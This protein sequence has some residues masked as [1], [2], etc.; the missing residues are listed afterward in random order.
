MLPDCSKAGLLAVLDKVV[1]L[2]AWSSSIAA[3]QQT[4]VLSRGIP[5]MPSSAHSKT[6]LQQIPATSADQ[7]RG[8]AVEAHLLWPRGL[9]VQHVEGPVPAPEVDLAIALALRQQRR[10]SATGTEREDSSGPTGALK[11]VAF[12]AGRSRELAF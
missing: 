2:A 12:T 1:R 11:S 10:D 7:S 6:R 5:R 3:T 4:F 9:I 8:C